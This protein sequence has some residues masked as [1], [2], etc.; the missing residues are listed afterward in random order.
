MCVYHTPTPNVPS[1]VHHTS[2]KDDAKHVAIHP[3]HQAKQVP[4]V[5]GRAPQRRRRSHEPPHLPIAFN[6]TTDPKKDDDIAKSSQHQDYDKTKPSSDRRTSATANKIS[7]E[8][9]RSSPPQPGP[10]T[11]PSFRHYFRD[12]QQASI[13]TKVDRIGSSNC[14]VL[15]QRALLSGQT[16][17]SNERSKRIIDQVRGRKELHHPTLQDDSTTTRVAQPTGNNNSNHQE[18]RTSSMS[19]TTNASVIA[20][21]IGSAS[22]PS[23]NRGHHFRDNNRYKAA[24][25]SS[26]SYEQQSTKHPT[27]RS[28]NNMPPWIRAQENRADPQTKPARKH[29]IIMTMHFQ[30]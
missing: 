1:E 3:A 10:R 16:T 6:I 14:T 17:D 13:G 5:G 28:S 25:T 15:Q 18:Q 30:G 8:T 19:S 4:H 12:K 7:S 24:S 9:T 26:P 2:K 29:I 22:A 23:S 21:N 20:I 11:A 27:T